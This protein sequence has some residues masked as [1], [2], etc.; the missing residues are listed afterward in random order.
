MN[1]LQKRFSQRDVVIQLIAVNVAVFLGV[2]IYMLIAGMNEAEG[3]ALWLL[4]TS[5]MQVLLHRPWSIITH[6]F[7]HENVGHIFFNMV[8]LYFMGG[9][10][11]SMLGQRGIL[12]LYL[13]GGLA[14][15]ALF[16]FSYN[17]IPR[18]VHDG[19]A[20]ILGASAAVM[21][22]TFAASTYA[23]RMQVA[24]FGVFRIE[25][26]WLALVLLALDLVSIRKGVNS[27]GSLAHLGGAAFGFIYAWQLQKGKNMLRWMENFFDRMKN[28]FSRKRKM[29]VHVNHARPKTDEQFNIEKK[30]Y[31]QKVDTILD[32]ISRAGYDS[33]SKEEKE[34]LF[35]SSQK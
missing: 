29:K 35:K 2:N 10:L 13:L 17:F 22:I 3:R 8:A 1:D 15:F 28:I 32:K 26:R 34:F 4:S 27:G 21:A 19:H 18:F 25:L 14:G 16:A 6:L 12:P 24:L 20:Y 31:Q 23:P 9:L 30:A 33:L 11:R 5:D 7:T